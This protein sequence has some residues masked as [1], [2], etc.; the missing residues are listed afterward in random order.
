[1]GLFYDTNAIA[2]QS[3]GFFSLTLTAKGSFS[4]KLHLAGQVYPFSGN[5]SPFGTASNSISLSKS[6]HVMILA[7]FTSG[8]RDILSGQI[9][10]GN[11]TAELLANRDDYSKTNLAPQ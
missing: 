10:N 5:F 6:N 11:W 8:G 2:F 3:S 1:S 7:G 9:S 4:A